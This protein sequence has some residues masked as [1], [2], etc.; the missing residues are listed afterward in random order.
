MYLDKRQGLLDYLDSL[1]K[2]VW[3]WI[4]DLDLD[5]KDPFFTDGTPSE[6]IETRTGID[7]DVV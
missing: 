6:L 7:V 3:F 5:L 2:V 1:W 4:L